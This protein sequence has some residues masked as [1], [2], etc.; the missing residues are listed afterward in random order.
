MSTAER[1]N[2]PEKILDLKTRIDNSNNKYP[3]S[4]KRNDTL[5]F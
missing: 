4:N 1:T 2:N 5:D 3:K